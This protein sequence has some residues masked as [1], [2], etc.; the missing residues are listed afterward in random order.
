MLHTCRKR[1][2]QVSERID[3]T[4]R[5]K[6]ITLIR[7]IT[8]TDILTASQPGRRP[9]LRACT[10]DITSLSRQIVLTQPHQSGYAVAACIRPLS[11][12]ETCLPAPGL[13]RCE[14][15]SA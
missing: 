10:T 8:L 2:P 1:S 4:Y 12:Q 11:L 7:Q 14:E 5:P 13:G 6:L 9:P 15:E 3:I